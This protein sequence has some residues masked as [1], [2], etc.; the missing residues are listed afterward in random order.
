MS[1][2]DAGINGVVRVPWPWFV[3]LGGAIAL[4]AK[5]ALS[6]RIYRTARE[7]VGEESMPPREIFQALLFATAVAHVGE[8]LAAGRMARRRG[9]PVA[10]LAYADVAGGGTGIADAAAG[11]RA[12]PPVKRDGAV[13]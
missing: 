1:V 13:R 12:A 9:L 11:P 4:L 3:V 10:R 8:A 5:L 6:G 7:V 2:E